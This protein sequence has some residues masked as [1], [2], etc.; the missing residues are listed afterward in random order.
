MDTEDGGHRFRRDMD[1]ICVQQCYCFGS[2]ISF[3]EDDDVMMDTEDGG[4][5]GIDFEGTWTTYV[6]NNV[7]VS[8]L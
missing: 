4:M 6:Y 2:L 8:I 7:I 5:V 3:K 1:D